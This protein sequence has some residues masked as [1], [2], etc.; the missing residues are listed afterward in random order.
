MGNAGKSIPVSMQSSR[1]LVKH[2]LKPLERN[3]GMLLRSSPTS[4]EPAD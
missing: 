2:L 4:C 1:L 3:A